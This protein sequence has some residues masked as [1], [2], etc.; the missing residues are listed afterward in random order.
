MNE[1]DMALNNLILKVKSGSHLYGTETETSDE[2]YIGIF[3]PDEEYILGLKHIDQVDLS[4]K[5]KDESGRNTS[6]A[7]DFTAY[8]LS[9]FVKLA[10]QNN[11]NILE[12]LYINPEDTE[13]IDEYGRSLLSIRDS[14]LS[15]KLVGRFYRYAVSQKHKMFLRS[16]NYQS[17]NHALDFLECLDGNMLM[18][19]LNNKQTLEKIQTEQP[20]I[21]VRFNKQNLPIALYLK[22]SPKP[23]MSI[24]YG[25]ASDTPK[26]YDVGDISIQ[27]N[28]Y[29][30]KAKNYIKNRLKR[31][32]HRGKNIIAKYNYDTKF[33]YHLIRLL[34]ECE[35]FI[36]TGKVEFPLS[37]AGYLKEI[38]LGEYSYEQLVAESETIERRIKTKTSG[39][40]L[41]L[42]KL[43]DFNFI[44]DF[45]VKL[46]RKHLKC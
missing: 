15:E 12:M 19:E 8:A 18:V 20:N 6:Q 25:K 29:V 35:E 22:D 40:N 26:F 2:D 10:L 33:A 4:I 46:Y 31:F 32:S 38:K 43:P 27:A 39:K 17:L 28:H 23:F 14:F 36:D 21:T 11:P 16:V 45:I 9:K 42:R 24:R 1:Q 5:S 3:I 37:Y 44:N 30:K 7:V 34:L 41:I 13:H